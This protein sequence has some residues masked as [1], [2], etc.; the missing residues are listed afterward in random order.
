VWGKE[1]QK[2]GTRILQTSPM[3]HR[4]IFVSLLVRDGVNFVFII[5]EF[6]VI[7]LIKVDI[8]SLFPR[9][10]FPEK[11]VFIFKLSSSTFLGSRVIC[12]YITP[13]K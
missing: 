4:E 1:L 6:S 7:S 10:A 3:S 5:V 12:I 11:A 13:K 8:F 2:G 9:G